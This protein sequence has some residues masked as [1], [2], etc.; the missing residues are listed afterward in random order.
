M[1]NVGI[2]ESN[3]SD[4][5]GQV[6][7]DGKETDP[8]DNNETPPQ[9]EEPPPAEN[10]AKP[11]EKPVIP[12]DKPIG[13][14]ALDDQPRPIRI[15]ANGTLDYVVQKGD[16]LYSLARR[17][18]LSLREIQQWNSLS[19]DDIFIGQTIKL[20]GKN[21]ETPT[22]SEHQPPKQENP[23]ESTSSVSIS[24]GNVN[25]KEI[26]F[27][28]DAGSDIAGIAILDVLKKHNVKATFFLTGKWVEKFPDHAKRIV[29][30]G[31]EIGSHGYSHLDA[32]RVGADTFKQDL[33]QAEQA[34]FKTTGMSPRP[35][36]RF[37]YGSFNASA[38]K[39]AGE[40]GYRYSI[41][42]SLDPI[43]WQQ[44]SSE[45]LLSRIENGASNGDIV[46]MHIGGAN[47]P[48]AVDKAIPKLKAHGYK[49]V[50]LTELLN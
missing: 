35:Y 21:A 15:P 25:K 41:Y 5:E 16:T 27:T 13:N 43:D 36:F 34:I 31:H 8:P 44:P 12:P 39:T 30:E 20:F 14:P 29:A 9:T 28:F 24:H 18:G 2:R 32:V 37:P 45:I 23:S 10:I 26:A 48:E 42:W 17:T 3:G 7:S 46:L 6:Q 49:L 4:K 1:S 50:T 11:P 33:T 22:P 40:A 19:S 38:L 47:T